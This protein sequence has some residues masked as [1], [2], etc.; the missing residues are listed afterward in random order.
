MFILYFFLSFFIY[1]I[2]LLL[3]SCLV[4][5][6]YVG[7]SSKW[8]SLDCCLTFIRKKRKKIDG[9]IL[10]H[11]TNSSYLYFEKF[12]FFFLCIIKVKCKKK[13]KKPIIVES[14][15]WLLLERKHL[16]LKYHSRRETFIKKLS[17][18][19]LYLPR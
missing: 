2:F 9:Y 7:E 16:F 14:E 17:Y 5:P 15:G 13:K 1:F 19:L 8:R 12:L 6:T 18:I 11:L 4:N 3:F 10:I